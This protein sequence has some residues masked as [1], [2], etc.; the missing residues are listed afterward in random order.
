MARDDDRDRK[1]FRLHVQRM[2]ESGQSP[3]F[4]FLTDGQGK[5]HD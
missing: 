3:S 2:I 5:W 1:A 4:A